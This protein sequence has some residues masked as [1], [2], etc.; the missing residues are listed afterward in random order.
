MKEKGEELFNET[1]QRDT[2]QKIY[3]VMKE[4]QRQLAGETD[5]SYTY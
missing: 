5:P 4:K 2:V 1:D 3:Y